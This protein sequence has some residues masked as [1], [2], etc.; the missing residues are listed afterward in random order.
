[1]K[2]RRV[3]AFA[4]ALGMAFTAAGCG[5]GSSSGSDSSASN[6]SAVA[7]SSGDQPTYDLQVISKGLNNSWMNVV[8]TGV[9]DTAD[10][11]NEEAGYEMVKASYTGPE[12]QSDIAVQVQQLNDAINSKPDCIAIS[13]LDADSVND[14]LQTALDTGIPVI[15]WDERL[16]NAPEGSVLCNVGTDN[17]EAATLDADML[18]EKIVDRIGVMSWSSVA[19]GHLNR[20]LGFIDKFMEHAAADG[21]TCCVTGNE[22]FVNG[23]A[24]ESVSE[25]DADIIIEVRV[26]A[27]T[28]TELAS[29]EAGALLNKS[30][31]IAVFGNTQDCT[32]GFIVANQNLNVLGT[33]DD[34]IIL[35]GFDAGEVAVQAIRDGVEYGGVNQAPYDIGKQTV[36]TMLKITQGEAVEDIATSYVW[37][38]VDNLEDE[39]VAQNLY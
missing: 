7:S 9:M 8:Q 20:G 2:K 13:A 4:L 31:T 11:I 29:T 21:Y 1:M 24:G 23:A 19:I 15:T 18:Y 34:D 39:D 26:P 22:A 28:T 17:Y 25:K 27:Q 35:V 33:G 37:Y 5:S 14:S 3:A 10:A 36:E 30:D 32:E 16:D 6:G 12:S 38:T